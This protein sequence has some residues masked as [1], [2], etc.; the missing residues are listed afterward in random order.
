MI[1]KYVVISLVVILGMGGSILLIK[2]H[3]ETVPHSVETNYMD[4]DGR[5]HAYQ[6]D[7]SS[8]YLSESIGLYMTYLVSIDDDKKF[9]E[10]YTQ[11]KSNFI[12]REDDTHH[13]P[14]IIDKHSTV[15]A[16]IDDVRIINALQ[17]A[18]KKFDKPVYESFATQLA[19]TIAQTQITNDLYTDFY[20]WLYDKKATRITLSYLTEEFLSA[21]PNTSTTKGILKDMPTNE[22][23]FPEYYDL[24]KHQYI[25]QNEIH[26]IDQLLIAINLHSIGINSAKFDT[27]LVKTWNDNHLLGRYDRKSLQP[28]V[29]YES[30]AVYSYLYYYFNLINERKIAKDVVLHSTELANNL[31]KDTHFF[32]FIHYQMMLIDNNQ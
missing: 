28:T 6:N 26:M 8:D 17:Q 14:W 18:S 13:I 25:K 11:L 29:S 10:Q 7:E 21:L 12:V 20:D 4:K 2:N 19:E 3:N 15:N 24:S 16:L 32:D 23:F 22:V 31:T 5:I 9:A 1:R 30:L 27:W